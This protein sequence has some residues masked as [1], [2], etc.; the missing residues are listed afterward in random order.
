MNDLV[1]ATYGY[2]RKKTGHAAGAL[3][4]L[5]LAQQRLATNPVD[6]L[7][8]IIGLTT[9]AD[10]E[11]HLDVVPDYKKPLGEVFCDA[12]WCLAKAG[13]LTFLDYI[14]HRPSPSDLEGDEYPSWVPKWHIGK[15][16]D[17]DP[18]FMSLLFDACPGRKSSA[19][20]LNSSTTTNEIMV[21]GVRIQ[22]IQGITGRITTAG[23]AQVSEL[24]ALLLQ[25]QDMVSKS[26]QHLED[27]LAI[28][29]TL[30]AGVDLNYKPVSPEI[31]QGYDNLLEKLH[32]D[33]ALPPT[34]SGLRRDSGMGTVLESQYLEAMGNACMN[35]AFFVT[36]NGHFGLGPHFAQ[37]GDIVAVIFGLRF[38]VVLRQIREKWQFL[39]TCYVHGI[40]NGEAV[41]VQQDESEVFTLR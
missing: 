35:R 34:I 19:P 30:V 21:D 1:D 3:Y 4:L 38:P 8:G 2:H 29:S 12:A 33:E 22:T 41:Q 37:A 6:K 15:D 25:I 10:G 23:F 36:T 18:N 7:Y 28:A 31:A 39:G 20:S 32:Q 17:E 24:R 16:L 14:R 13:D 26:G 9:N 40:M 27:S 11:T 5:D